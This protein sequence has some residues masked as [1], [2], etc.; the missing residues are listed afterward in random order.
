MNVIVLKIC[1]MVFWVAT[2]IIRYPH[3]QRQKK[4]QIRTDNKDA[5]EKTLL[6]GATIGIAI[7][8]LLYVFTPIFSF[9]DYQLPLWINVLGLALAPLTLWLFWRSHKDLGLNWSA[10]LEV[11]EEHSLVTNGVYKSIRHPMYTAIWLWGLLQACLLPNYIGGFSTLI[12]FGIL[13][14]LRVGKEEK[15]M[16]QTF[17]EE[18]RQYMKQ[19][20]RIFPHFW[21]KQQN[22]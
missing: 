20:G 21:L 5:L 4:N 15:M 17:G 7:L 22:V 3:G 19:T 2:G 12:F 18:Y 9:A 8:P 1:F 6:A 14:F 13:Y 16:Q 11:R 10:S